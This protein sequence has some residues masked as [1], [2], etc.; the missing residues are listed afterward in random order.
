MHV[1]AWYRGSPEPK[2]IEFGELDELLSVGQ[3]LNASKFYRCRLNDVREKTLQKFYSLQNFGAS[4]DSLGQNSPI[5]A[6]MYG[7]VASIN[8]PNFVPF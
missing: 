8:R 4:G 6:M 2:F 7:N 3:T 1:A 5:S